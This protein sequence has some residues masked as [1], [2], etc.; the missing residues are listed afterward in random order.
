MKIFRPFL[1]ALFILISAQGFAQ[2]FADEIQ[3]FKTQDAAKPPPEHAILFIGSSSFRKWTDVASYFPGY[4]IINRGFGGSTFPDLVRYAPDI[5]FPYHPKQV[6]IYCGDNDLASSD[7]ISSD[8]VFERFKVLFELIRKN[9]PGEN[10]VYVS[11]KPSPSRAKLF[12]KMQNANLLIQTYLSINNQAS[13]V[14]VFDKMLNPDGSIMT[15][16]F[17][18]DN[19]HMNAKGYA[20]WQ[21]A[22]TPYLYK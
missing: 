18:E 10:I 19:L 17:L 13:F 21:K 4:T 5:I 3:T 12:K 6:V 2:P 20:I 14:N 15:D 1:A 16:I 7:S 8:S 11:I 22:M 9:M